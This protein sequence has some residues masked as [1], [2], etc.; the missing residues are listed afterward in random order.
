MRISRVEGLAEAGCNA[1][2]NAEFS[3][4]FSIQH[5][6][7]SIPE[8][9][10]QRAVSRILFPAFAPDGATARRRSFL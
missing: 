8:V 4:H 7:F 2:V 9:P 6:A 5:S 10:P 1:E 3:I